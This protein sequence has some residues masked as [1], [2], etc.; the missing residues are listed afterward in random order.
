MKELRLF[1]EPKNEQYYVLY[2]SP[3]KDLLFKVDQ[4]NPAMLS[5]VYENALFLSSHE[6][7]QVIEEMEIFI[8]NEIEKLGDNYK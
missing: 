6:R 5:R 2:R 1:Y 4:F 3:G 7:A 8:R